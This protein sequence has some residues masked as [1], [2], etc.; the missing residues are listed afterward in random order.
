MGYNVILINSTF[1]LV[2]IIIGANKNPKTDVTTMQTIEMIPT[3]LKLQ[4]TLI[5]IVLNSLFFLDVTC[6]KSYTKLIVNN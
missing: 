2:Q 4:Q 3:A 5:L 6:W 1:I